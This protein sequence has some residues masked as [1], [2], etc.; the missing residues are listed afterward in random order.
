MIH[1]LNK[2]DYVGGCIMEK[3]F[4]FFGSLSNSISFFSVDFYTFFK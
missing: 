3:L 2:Y 1:N 4:Y